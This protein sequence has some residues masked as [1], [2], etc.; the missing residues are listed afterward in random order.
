[1][2]GFKETQPN[3]EHKSPE[4]RVEKYE[5][6]SWADIR[7][8]IMAIEDA[9]FNQTGYGEGMMESLF[10]NKDNLNYLLKNTDGKIIGYTQ[11]LIRGNSAYIMNTA[12][13]PEHQGKG[14]VAVL[15]QDLEEELRARGVKWITR[16]S[17]VENGYADKI[18]KHYG[19]RIVETHE[20][21]SSWGLQ[22]YF[23]IRL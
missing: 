11:A 15:M 13:T 7:E 22:R 9:V 17:V 14:S 1:M 21:E 4:I 10:E 23:R 20:R 6:N 18:Q 2:S 5:S 16:D 3:I 19:D 12:I 8:S